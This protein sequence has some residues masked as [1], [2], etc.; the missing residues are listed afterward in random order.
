MQTPTIGQLIITHLPDPA[1]ENRD[2]AVPGVVLVP[3]Q[4]V[5]IIRVRDLS[6]HIAEIEVD[7]SKLSTRS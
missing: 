2:V 6:T 4:E 3:G 5:T 1:H 7:N